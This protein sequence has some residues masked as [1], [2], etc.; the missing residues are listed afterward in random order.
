[1]HSSV[2]SIQGSSRQGT[3]TY[4]FI[5]YTCVLKYTRTTRARSALACAFT[6]PTPLPPPAALPLP[7]FQAVSPVL[8][9]IC[10]ALVIDTRNHRRW[11][12]G[13]CA[14]VALNLALQLVLARTVGDIGSDNQDDEWPRTVVRFVV[15]LVTLDLSFASIHRMFHIVPVLWHFHKEHHSVTPPDMSGYKAQFCHPVEHVACNLFPVALST[16]TAGLSWTCTTAFFCFAECSSVWAHA[17]AYSYHA[18]HHTQPRRHF[19][20]GGLITDRIERFIFQ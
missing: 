2:P 7:M 16:W 14:L 6:S 11:E 20:L 17:D 8:T 4:V 9:Y 13:K 15:A 12:T 19:G 5:C 3:Y 10:A 1:M 18:Q